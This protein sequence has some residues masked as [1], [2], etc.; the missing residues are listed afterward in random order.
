MTRHHR[1]GVR[2]G[3]ALCV[4]AC[5]LVGAA[6]TTPTS[7]QADTPPDQ[8]PLIIGTEHDSPP[9]SYQAPDGSPTGFNVELTRAV[10]DA[11]GLDVEI[12]YRPWAEIRADLEAGKIDAIAGMF[13]SPERD[14][15]VDF[16]PPYAIV[17]HAAFARRGTPEITGVED[18]RGK[19][20]IVMRDDIMHDFVRDHD[21]TTDISPAD[22]QADVLQLL[23]EGRH[24]YALIAELPGL[25]WARELELDNVEV[26]SEPLLSSRLCFAV[27]EGDVELRFRLGEG[28]AILNQTNRYNEIYD[29][30]LGALEPQPW[31]SDTALTVVAS[32]VGILTLGLIGGALW[33]RSLRRQVARRTAA[34][35]EEIAERERVA[36]ALRTSEEHQQTTLNSIGDA[37]ITTDA[38]GVVT[39]MNP[40]AERLTGW[41]QA[42]AR[43]QALED[44]FHIVNAET[45]EPGENP[46]HRVL[47]TG[48]IIGLANHTALI[49]KDGTEYQI[50]DSAA[51]IRS[52]GGTTIGVVLVFRDVTEAYQV[53][54]RLQAS[55]ERFRT[56]LET[57]PGAV[58]AHD[59]DGHIVLVNAAAVRNTGWTREELLSMSVSDIDPEAVT[60][61]DRERL[62]L[63]LDASHTLTFEVTHRRKDGTRY[64]AEV[65]LNSVSLEGEPIILAI[66]Y[67]ITERKQAEAQ[68]R[69]QQRLAAVG[70]LSAGI[71]HDFRNALT[72]ISLSANLAH[73]T[74]ADTPRAAR[75]L[76]AIIEE[77]RKAAELVQQILD[78][79]GNAML[80]MAPHD[81]ATL[82]EEV[83]DVLRRTIPE[84]VRLSLDVTDPAPD[85][86]YIVQADPGRIQQMLMN[87]A[88]NAHDAMPHGGDL[89]IEL[90]PLSLT[91]E[92]TP[93]VTGMAPG[94]WVCLSVSDTGTGMGPE[95]QAHL[96]EPFF[97]TKP[98]DKG[99]GLGLA[100]VWGI[101]QQHGGQIDVETAAGQGTT[102][103]IYFP[104][105]EGQPKSRPAESADRSPVAGDGET[106]LLVEDNPQLRDATREI[107]TSLGYHVRVAAQGREALALHADHGDI[108]LVV[109]DIVMPDMGGQDLIEALHRRDPSLRAIGITGYA[110]QDLDTRIGPDGFFDIL[111]KP[112]E[113][114]TLA[115]TVRRA[116]DAP[117]GRWL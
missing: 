101:V 106:I 57:L 111:R 115:R 107:L 87:L 61:R 24:D 21:L 14:Q 83:L 22:T 104:R 75:H 49:A 77:S 58:F 33:T 7:A 73:R 117:A 11:A 5:L 29:R 6:R 62:W 37:V 35:T 84:R 76:N 72:T 19:A 2:L 55:E 69:R 16:S 64:P 89:R 25:Y 1:V 41:S 100:Q 96:F 48:R 90:H 65:H 70:Q 97:T 50:A 78:F 53:R 88:L 114:A 51:P 20:L 10:A 94:D 92:D 47:E 43:G 59:L 3:L 27:A 79:S 13:Y 15:V 17:H 28:L 18:L 81:L 103:R 31:I 54:Q 32:V 66:A 40:V 67:D 95:V 86:A 42:E 110:V 112:F 85:T 56:V 39:G 4:A 68:I 80:R 113:I 82:T 45:R 108:D 99:T 12:D 38:A 93:P 36:A 105:V 71:A 44:V 109:T 98:V 116:L 8:P 63:K 60:R 91:P 74:V 52:N 26:V 30:W 102:F 34:L 23:A 9:Y 46:A